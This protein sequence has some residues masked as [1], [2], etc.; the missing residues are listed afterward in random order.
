MPSIKTHGRFRHEGQEFKL[1]LAYIVNPKPTGITWGPVL[2]KQMDRN[3]QISM[4]LT[5]TLIPS[6]LPHIL[7]DFPTWYYIVSVA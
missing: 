2:N 3:K 4:I 7:R 1:G 6:Y 5:I